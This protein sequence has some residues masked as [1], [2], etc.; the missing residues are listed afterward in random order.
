MMHLLPII[1]PEIHTT[2]R[3]ELWL[4]SRRTVRRMLRLELYMEDPHCAYCRRPLACPDAGV[5]DHATPRSQGGS[6][7]PSNAMLC[8]RGCDHAKGPRTISEW[9]RVY[10]RGC[11][12]SAESATDKRY[13]G[14]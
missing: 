11:S 7:Q 10:L 9:Q 8:C 5:L 2:R 3:M 1:N 6:N 4:R 12:P 13:S 14:A